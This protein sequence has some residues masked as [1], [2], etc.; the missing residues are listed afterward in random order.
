MTLKHRIQQY[1]DWEDNNPGSAALVYIMLIA[2]V[3]LL[4]VAYSVTP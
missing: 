4:S 2:I 1:Y 3:G